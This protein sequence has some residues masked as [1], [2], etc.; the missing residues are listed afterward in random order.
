MS[1]YEYDVFISYRRGLEVKDWV[2]DHFHPLLESKLTQELPVAPRIFIDHEM[3]NGVRWEDTIQR[4]LVRSKILL[5]V[6]NPSYFESRWCQA[7]WQTILQREKDCEVAPHEG[8]CLFSVIYGDGDYFPD[9]AGA[10]QGQKFHDYAVSAPAFRETP[11]YL[12]FE[13]E[14]A[15][16]AKQIVSRLANAPP[17]EAT[18]EA[19]DP[20]EIELKPNKPL[21]SLK[22]QI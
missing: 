7:E 15:K 9:E 17:W 4:A 8:G 2:C 1:D 14:V 13:K 16:V 11:L 22:P 5:G 12:E 3:E 21:G 20:D 18:W 6:W 10:R 19:L